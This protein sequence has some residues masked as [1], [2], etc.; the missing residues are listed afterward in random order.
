VAISTHQEVIAST[1][2]KPTWQQAV[3]AYQSSDLRKSL[4]QMLTSIAPYFI[5][6]YLAYRS[7]EVSYWVTLFIAV[8][9]GLFGMRVFIIFHDCGHGSFSSR[10]GRITSSALSPASSHLRPIMRGGTAMPFTTQP[11][12]TS[13]M[14][15]GRR[16]LTYDEYMTLPR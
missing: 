12:A 2:Q 4:W 3:A 5:L 11:R 14:R 9:A 8:F 1:A 15:R 13:T 10:A 16:G 7:L 6:W